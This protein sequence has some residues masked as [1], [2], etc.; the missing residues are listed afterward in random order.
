MRHAVY[1]TELGQHP[2]NSRGELRDSLD[3]F[4]EYLVAK[5]G[6]KIVGFVSITLPGH[7]R[8]SIDKYVSRDALPFSFDEGL[9]E[10]RLLTVMPPYRSSPLAGLLMYG[11]FRWIEARG[12]SRIVAIGRREVLSLYRKI[13]FHALGQTI[14]CGAV[15]FELMEIS[16]ADGRKQ[17]GRWERALERIASRVDWRL[18]MPWIEPGRCRHGGRFF[19][20]IGDEFERLERRREI[21]NADVLDAWFPPAPAVLARLREHLDWILRTSPPTGCDGMLRAIARARGV[22]FEC[23]VP[24]AGSS[25]LI[26]LAFH[27]WLTRAS[28]VLILD[29]TYGEYAHVL[30]R[31]IKCRVDRLPLDR[32][33]GYRLDLA[34]LEERLR[35]GYDLV[36]LVNPNNPTGVHVPRAEWETVLGRAPVGTRFWIDEAYVDYVGQEESLERFA[37]ASEN[38][39]V[40]KSMSKVY[41][42]SGVRAAYL[43]APAAIARQLLTV[44]PPWAVGLPGQ[45]AAV[46]ALDSPE[47]YRDRYRETHRLRGRLAA[48]L[49][50]SGRIEVHPGTANYLLCHLREDRFTAAEFIA[51]CRRQGLF[52]RD[53][54]SMMKQSEPRAFRVAVKDDETNARIAEIVSKNVRSLA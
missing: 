14:R 17:L 20:A 45:I 35:Q 47:Y 30:E 26:F 51:R 54:G 34:R 24:G 41:A 32:R 4:N 13:G 27:Q 25:N 3:D 40:S 28:R 48:A 46:A 5:R 9:Y 1:A 42:L 12:G 23:L 10:A 52:L 21:I 33:E 50:S 36:A 39:V 18:A 44:T 37:A 16:V 29:P 49:E 22:P 7:G 2:E 19:E 38:V 6:G 15:E 31:L 43:C 11:A 8:Y 53:V